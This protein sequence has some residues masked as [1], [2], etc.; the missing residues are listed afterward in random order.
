MGALKSLGPAVGSIVRNPVLL[1]VTGL[2]AL[3][4]L[5]QFA[6]QTQPSPSISLVLLGVSL[7]LSVLV[8]V[9]IPF[10]QGGLIGMAGE[11][12]GGGT[13]LGTLVSEGKSNYVQLLLTYL[14]VVAINFTFGIFAFIGILIGGIGLF[15]GDADP[16]LATIAIFG[17]LASIVVLA[18]LVVYFFVQFYPQAIVL[19]DCDVVESFKRSASLV[20]GNVL[21]T[22]GYT[23]LLTI[24]GGLFG[25]LGAGASLLASGEEI[26]GL[27][28]PEVTTPMLAG[29]AVAYI[30]LTGI[31]GAFYATYSVSFYRDLE[32]AADAA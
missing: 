18:Y 24:G 16:S 12:L 10:L 20:R 11:A 15:A 9:F 19:S 26:P 1:V 25:L 7:L 5:P 32:A 13:S 21:S 4:Q 23:I 28:L 6:L 2:Y 31:A 8:L 17:V 3:F 29:L 22:L 27:A 30:L 14:I